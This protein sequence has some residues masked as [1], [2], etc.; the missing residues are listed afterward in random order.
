MAIE[1]YKHNKVAYDNVLEHYKNTNRTCVIHPTGSG[2]S[3]I[4]LKFIEDNLNG[5][6]LLLAPTYPILDQFSSN[7][8]K[9]I[10][11]IDTSKLSQSEINN[12]VS[13]NFP[14][15]NFSIYGN[16]DK[17]SEKKYD[18]IVMDEFHRVGAESWGK[19]VNALLENN[20][21]A[22][23][24]G[25]TATPIRYL[26]DFRNMADEIFDGDISSEIT[27]GQA[28]ARG[29][30]P[31]PKYVSALYSFDEELDRIE[32]KI[33]N[34]KDS[35]KRKELQEKIKEARNK[36]EKADGLPEILSKHITKH[37]GKFIVFC[38]NVEHMKQM[39]KEAMQW[40]VNVNS[41][42]DISEVHTYNDRITNQETIANFAKDESSKLK[43]LFSV[44]MLNEGLHVDDIDG[45]IMLRPT[46]SPIIYLQQ[47]GRALS[48]GH[49]S[50]PLVFDIV[51]N[52]K[53]NIEIYNLLKQVKEEIKNIKEGKSG[54]VYYGGG[55]VDDILENFTIFDE[56]L[57]LQKE[58]DS[59][60]EEATFKW[61]EY[62]L[63]SKAY[64]ETNGHLL[65]PATYRTFNGITEVTK[66]DPRYDEAY[67]LGEWI[68]TQ[69]SNKKNNMITSERMHLLDEINMV[70]D[71]IEKSWNDHYQL[72]KKFYETNGHLNI[73]W[74]Y[75]TFDGITEVTKDDP[76]YDEAI[77]LGNWINMQRN[78]KK[79]IGKKGHGIPRITPEQIQL[80][81]EIGMIWE[82]FENTW[83]EN[84]KL[85]KAYYETNGH[86]NIPVSYRTFD[87]IIEIK[88][89]EPEY[90]DAIQ[91]GSWL[92][93]QR[94]AKRG[95]GNYSITPEQ[96]QLLEEIGIVW[97]KVDDFWDRSFAI[98]ETFYNHYGHL[99]P[100]NNFRTFDGVTP[101]LKDDPRY[102]EAY[103]LSD[104][105]TVQRGRKTGAR[106]GTITPE[107][108]AKLESIG[109]IWDLDEYR[110]NENYKLAKAYYETNGHLNML[111][112][113][114]TFD[115]ITEVTKDDPRYDEAIPLGT[116]ITSQRM[117]Y[118][119]KAGLT[120]E[121][122][123][124]LE[125]IGMIWYG[126]E[127][128]DDKAQ[129]EEITDKNVKRKR[130]EILNRFFSALN[131]FKGEDEMP[132]KEDI[133]QEFIDELNHT[134]KRR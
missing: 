89:D 6:V 64:Y 83:N 79:S 91:L 82:Y 84:Y 70:W 97:E 22:K 39:E 18:S 63:L 65:I 73:K 109:M 88:K 108:I 30:L 57:D 42:I 48:V 37:N 96:I 114:R 10:L 128:F 76:R 120:E 45:V 56:M 5:R 34:Y 102:D 7:I 40:F 124:K 50:N 29:I 69:R 24:L 8:A 12:I 71:V 38:K 116:W 126:K 20:I 62:Y 119:G 28:I 58:L 17:I 110:W 107:Q 41:K 75:R 105:L 52:Y 36:I 99:H 54:S 4:S 14:N 47:I 9:N 32:K 101:V 23:V 78:A 59:I 121:R 98:A 60:D 74:N 16:V 94:Q 49:N 77:K 125:S 33:N 92:A 117:G 43:L 21:E 61:D 87:G 122:L 113:Y 25:V 68:S 31:A 127:S 1:L 44:Q 85:A 35:V 123:R 90:E 80:L 132:S 95:T 131:S 13:T 55:S 3:F 11:G 27:L 106:K 93:T 81:E 130:I 72:A 51:N 86:L 134:S 115:G 66:D 46:G 104:W 100:D 67:Q 19:G 112:T 111:A 53:E 103:K 118:T 129:K 2:K 26:D 133:N 15:I